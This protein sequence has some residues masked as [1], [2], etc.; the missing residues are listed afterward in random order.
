MDKT[1]KINFRVSE[2]LKKKI[3]AHCEKEMIPVSQYIR[4]LI[5][6]NLE[7]K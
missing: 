5:I 2:E 4:N 1:E 7:E 6:K 3:E